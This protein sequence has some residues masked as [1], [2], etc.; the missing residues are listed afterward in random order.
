MDECEG[1][2]VRDKGLLS[3]CLSLLTADRGHIIDQNLTEGNSC[4]D[5]KIGDIALIKFNR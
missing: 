2:G 3:P 4:T 5:N 1:L